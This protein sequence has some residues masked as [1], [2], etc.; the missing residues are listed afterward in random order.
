MSR[1]VGRIDGRDVF[2]KVDVANGRET[3]WSSG[4]DLVVKLGTMLPLDHGRVERA[5]E[6]RVC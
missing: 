4:R 6:G 1:V 3:L 5:V 2:R